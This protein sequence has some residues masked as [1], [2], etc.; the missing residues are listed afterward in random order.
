MLSS[1]GSNGV[2]SSTNLLGQTYP[3]QQTT[4]PQEDLE[5]THQVSFFVQ[6][7]T[8]TLT[9]YRGKG[10]LLDC[11]SQGINLKPFLYMTVENI[12]RRYKKNIDLSGSCTWTIVGLKRADTFSGRPSCSIIWQDTP[13]YWVWPN[14]IEFSNQES[15]YAPSLIH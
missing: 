7:D 13:F 9:I 5:M 4:I 8:N 6:A 10:V 14:A 1:K 2:N 15:C 3:P 11:L 12:A